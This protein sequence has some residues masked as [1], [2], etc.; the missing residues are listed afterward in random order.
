VHVVILGPSHPWRGGIAHH[1]ASLFGELERCGHQ[2]TLLNFHRLYPEFLFPGKTQRDESEA[3]FSVPAEAIFDPIDP[4]SW[5][6]IASKLHTIRP[7]RLIL[8][9][10]HP[11]FAPG[12]AAVAAAARLVGCEVVMMCH[13]VEPHESTSIDRALLRVAYAL[14]HRFVVQS[15][16]ERSRL[17]SLVGTTRP[18]AV[19]PHPPYDMFSGL[20]EL[21]SRDEA[22]SR[23]GVDAVHLLLFFGLVRPYKGLDLLLEAVALLPEEL[24][25]ELIVAGEV[26]GET[27]DYRRQIDEHGI[28]DRVRLDDRYVPNE[29]VPE[30]FRAA[31]A[32]VLPYRQ[33]TGSGAANVALACGTD[34]IMSRLPTL[35]QAFGDEPVVWFA[36]EDVAGLR[37]AIVDVLTG[38]R[39]VGRAPSDAAGSASSWQQLVDA[40]IDS[41]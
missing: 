10:W 19:A 35:E 22:K 14:P 16:A 30:L 29:E 17:E 6:R 27:D 4:L 2:V 36:P 40:L 34:L 32:C 26:Y 33:A 25:W 24:D 18:I 20:A 1:S 3:A 7:D 13:N 9:W 15:S 11:F 8:Q 21:S 39:S 5:L 37:D 41:P 38:D 23:C 28:A 12:Y 31:S